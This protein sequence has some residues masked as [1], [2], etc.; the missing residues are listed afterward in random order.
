VKILIASDSFKDSL[1]ALEVCQAIERGILKS[2]SSI[3]TEI[4]PLADG[5]EGTADILTQYSQGKNVS[6]IVADPLFREIEASYGISADGQTAFIEM[7]AASGIQL[8][9][10][11]E[12]NPSLTTTYGTGQLI[13]DAVQRGVKKI[14]LG[15]GSS[16][17]NDGGMGMAVALGFQFWDEYGQLLEGRGSELSLVRQI[18]QP[19]I[20]LVSSN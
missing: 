7:A 4:C 20:N 12:R 17:T 11:T 15:I 18:D 14:I 1:S 3:E 8:L 5:G 19:K 16:A 10:S 2:D 6:I 13:K 9:T